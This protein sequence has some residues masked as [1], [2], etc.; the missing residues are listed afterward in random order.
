MHFN[1]HIYI[2]SLYSAPP[3]PPVCLCS[4]FDHVLPERVQLLLLR[5]LLDFRLPLVRVLLV[6]HG[7]CLPGACNSYSDRISL[8][9]PLLVGGVGMGRRQGR[10]ICQ[11]ISLG[12]LGSLATCPFGDMPLVQPPSALPADEVAPPP[13]GARSQAFLL[14]MSAQSAAAAL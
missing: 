6:A 9:F 13:L 3:R 1:I 8:L 7:I 11:Q 4:S 14:A 2:A 5:L 10:Q 12:E